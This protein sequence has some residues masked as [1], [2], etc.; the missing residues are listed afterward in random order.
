MITVILQ[1]IN[2]RYYF[3]K[4]ILFHKTIF[5]NHKKSQL[6]GTDQHI[7]YHFIFN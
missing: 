4:Q 1:V 5:S 3:L 2:L 6:E 7:D